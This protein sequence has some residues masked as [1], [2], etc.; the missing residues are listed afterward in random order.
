M[1]NATS[2]GASYRLVASDKW[3]AKSAVL[4]SAVTKALVEYAGPQPGM[5]VLD[6]ASG[7]GEPAIS[8]AECVGP[9]GSVVA[10]DMSYELLEIAAQRAEQKELH[11][12]TT[13]QAD[14][15][16]LPF[17]D[18]S[19]DL[20]TCRFA[21]MFFVDTCKALT[22]LRRVLKPGARACFVAWGSFEQPY[23]QTTMKIVHKHV[24]GNLLVPGGA[25]PFRF[26]TSGFLS[27]ELKAA[28]FE[29]VEESTQNLPWTWPGSAEEVFEYACAVA[30]PLRPLME[31]ARPERIPGIVAEAREAIE[32][33]RVGDE[34]RFGI[35]VVMA[36]GKA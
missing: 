20:A 12:F 15:H 2:W 23:W 21:V 32:R 13:E 22:E 31:R 1:S 18:N 7:T 10:T 25:N 26:S 3:K 36:S 19:F 30:A 27:K 35:D 8:L 4:G 29:S 6:L 17:P 14:A 24:G 16:K 11:N 33:Y 9:Q 34:I 5:Q 28:G